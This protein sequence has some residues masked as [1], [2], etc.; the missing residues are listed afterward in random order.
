MR[1]ICVSNSVPDNELRKIAE[2]CGSVSQHEKYLNTAYEYALI[3]IKINFVLG[4]K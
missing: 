4:V 2:T 1:G 3:K